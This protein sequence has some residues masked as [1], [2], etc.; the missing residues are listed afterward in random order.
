MIF[1]FVAIF[2]RRKSVAKSWADILTRQ[3]P[4]H[5]PGRTFSPGENLCANLGDHF[6][7]AKTSVQTWA[8]IFARK[9]PVQQSCAVIFKLLFVMIY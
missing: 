2:N 1:S 4:L 5:K 6:C 3:K 7:Q 9:K 8:D